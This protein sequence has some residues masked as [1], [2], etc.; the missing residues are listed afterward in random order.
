MNKPITLALAIL[1]ACSVWSFADKR[2]IRREMY[3][4]TS[5]DFA[6]YPACQTSRDRSCILAIR[7]YDA[8]TD[9]KLAEVKTDA[10]MR[11]TQRI[12][13]KADGAI[14]HRVYAATVY[15]DNLGAVTEGPHGQATE[16]REL[17]SGN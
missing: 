10:N 9:K 15:L 14:P 2:D 13:A 11:G 17:A 12:V 1:V 6:K 8:A 16:L 3:L 7:F 5:F 4:V